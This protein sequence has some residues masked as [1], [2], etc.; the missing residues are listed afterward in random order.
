MYPKNEPLPR[1]IKEFSKLGKETQ[2][3]ILLVQEKYTAYWWNP[4]CR[5]ECT[6][7]KKIHKFSFE[8]YTMGTAVGYFGADSIK[9]MKKWMKS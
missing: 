7:H 1:H 3:I 2:R 9:E 4:Y 6:T 8:A 5:V